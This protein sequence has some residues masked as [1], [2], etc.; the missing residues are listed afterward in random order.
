[1][2]I[3]NAI[4]CPAYYLEAKGFN[5]INQS[6]N[7]V[8]NEIA[9]RII[10]V[11]APFLYL[12]QIVLHGLA[13]V[14]DVA[15]CL[16]G[17]TPGILLQSTI[18]SVMISTENFA[19]SICEIPQKLIFGPHCKPNYCGDFDRYKRIDYLSTIGRDLI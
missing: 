15:L 14:V 13:T 2:T 18:P 6:K 5:P 3:A 17:F 11:V 10:A 16:P 4:L 7:R 1:M 8:I 19:S 9:A 12:Y